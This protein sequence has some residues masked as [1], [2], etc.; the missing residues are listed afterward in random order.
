MKEES[1]NTKK[2][3]LDKKQIIL[4]VFLIFLILIFS[5]FLYVRKNRNSDTKQ[6]QGEEKIV[7][8]LEDEE[9]LGESLEEENVEEDI[10]EST[11]ESSKSTTPSK[12]SESKEPKKPVEEKTPEKPDPPKPL[13]P[14]EQ[15][16]SLWTPDATS[17]IIDSKETITI[18]GT[19][20]LTV[21]VRRGT[22]K[23]GDTLK[24]TGI[25]GIV[26]DVSTKVRRMIKA[27]KLVNSATV[28]ESVGIAMDNDYFYKRATFG[29]DMQLATKV[30]LKVY[31]F[32]KEEGNS[33]EQSVV[34]NQGYL[35]SFVPE[36]PSGRTFITGNGTPVISQPI[37]PGEVAEIEVKKFIM[38]G[39]PALYEPG[40]R[41]KV[42]DQ[43]T[44]EQIGI[45]VIT[46][47]PPCPHK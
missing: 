45:A 28:S 43:N 1:N 24:Q 38:L 14:R 10:E 46:G 11:P 18:N 15:V 44:N 19:K 16:E 36:D 13:T 17:V 26:P 25:C 42:K 29:T 7:S 41:I 40:T 5:V 35:L 39:G 22:L 21:T 27:G 37:K 6:D 4:L 8:E 3:S 32:T 2:L 20:Y 12:P 9:D 47:Y 30:K 34:N 33:K 23:V 31:V